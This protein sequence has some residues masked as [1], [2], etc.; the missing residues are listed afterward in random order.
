M[1]NVRKAK[2]PQR[3]SGAVGLPYRTALQSVKFGIKSIEVLCIQLILRYAQC[4]S[5]ALEMD[6]LPFAQELYRVTDI[7][8]IAEAKDVVIGCSSFLL[9]CNA[10]GTTY[11]PFISILSRMP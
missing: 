11:F 1:P 8:I 3:R 7:G 4:L 2:V 10:A 5:E 6:Y 9:C